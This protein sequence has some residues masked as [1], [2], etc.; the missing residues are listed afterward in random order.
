MVVIEELLRRYCY[1]VDDAQWDALGEVF[2]ADVRFVNEFSGTDLTGIGPVTN[3]YRSGRHPAAHLLA[4]VLVAPRS[5]GRA[6]ARAKYLTVQ[7]TGLVGTGEYHDDLVRTALGWRVR[8]R[9]VIV[10]SAPNHT[11]DATA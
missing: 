5:D 7:H 9:V 10:R 11:P 8:E 1:I 4:N 6:S 3:W 2:T